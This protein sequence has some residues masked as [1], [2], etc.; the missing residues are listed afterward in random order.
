MLKGR[1][2]TVILGFLSTLG[3]LGRDC[4]SFLGCCRG[5]LDR[6]GCQYDQSECCVD[7][8]KECVC[9]GGGGDVGRLRKDV[10]LFIRAKA[11]YIF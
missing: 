6:D 9:V 11:L 8:H 1:E 10:G 4:V 3:T 7:P 2:D 5:R